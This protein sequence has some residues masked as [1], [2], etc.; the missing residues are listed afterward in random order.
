MTVGMGFL[1]LTMLITVEAVAD[2]RVYLSGG[3]GISGAMADTD[4]QQSVGLIPLSGE[5]SDSSPL[6][7]GAVGLEI[8]M[9]ELLP[10]EWLLDVRL[11]DWPTRFEIEAAGLR[12]YEFRTVAG[13]DIFFTDLESTTAFVNTWLDIPLVSIYRPVQ[14]TLG[15]GRQP[16]VRQWLEPGS[17]Y[18]GG[19]IG[20]S[21]VDVRGTS[22]AISAS[23][24]FIE[25]A[26]NLGAGVNYALTDRVSISTGYRYVGVGP[27]S[28]GL[29]DLDLTPSGGAPDPGDRLKYKLQIHELRVQVRVELFDF[30]NPW[31]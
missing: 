11:P 17:F 9:D 28:K 19:G 22:N 6:V 15:L 25:F 14:Y 30:R 29:G 31:R 3:L 18:I 20:F 12:E 13:G 4:G 5:D 16:R 1:T 8:P 26:W 2:W 7:D 21:A 27:N 10:R 23:D 24:D